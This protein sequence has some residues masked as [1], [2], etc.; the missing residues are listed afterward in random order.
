MQYIIPATADHIPLI[1]KMALRIWPAAYR[2]ILTHEQIQNMLAKIYSE[3]GLANEMSQGHRFW[4][5]YAENVPSGYVSAYKQDHTIWIKKL[6]VDL[7][8]QRGGLGSALLEE[9][10]RELSPAAEIKLL[11]NKN[12][13][14]AQGYYEHKGFTRTGET[15]VKMGDFEFMDYLYTKEIK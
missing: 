8:H 7:G 10:V 12:N 5:I 2:E 15:P 13:T 9:A 1:R 11:V 14:P 3:E 6:Y 4:L